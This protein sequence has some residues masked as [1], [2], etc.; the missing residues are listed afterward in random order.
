MNAACVGLCLVVL[1]AWTDG[2]RAT[3]SRQIELEPCQLESDAGVASVEAECGRLSVPEDRAD[4]SGRQIE[5]RVAVVRAGSRDPAQTPLFVLAGGPGQA[6][7][8]FYAAYAPAFRWVQR[9]RDIV[10]VDQ[11]GTGGSSA[12]RC[13]EDTDLSTPAVFDPTELRDRAASCLAELA[14]DPRHYT[15]SVAVRDLDTVREALGYG[16]IDLYGVSYGTRVAQH[17]LRRF[18]GQVRAMVLDGAVP[19]EVVLGPDTGPEA[20]RALDAILARCVA[21]PRCSAAFPNVHSDFVELV[22]RLRQAPLDLSVP[23]PTTAEPIALRFDAQQLGAALRI[24]S[25]SDETAALLPLLI[26]EAADRGYAEPLAAQYLMVARRL[27]GQLAEGMHNAVVCTED[28]PF[29][30]P[31]AA[32]RPA[33]TDAYLG[34]LQ[35]EGLAAICSVWPR[36]ELDDDLRSPLTIEV[37][38][39]LL[40]GEFD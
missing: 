8:E 12:L 38:L 4:P 27:G 9:A 32:T 39:L 11:R 40:S 1:A 34:T 26:N 17:Y 28:V 13:P 29:I 10:L 14:G 7:T 19:P 30:D 21:D 2:D 31:G 24:L 15:T 3:D 33:I 16:Q 22:D 37:P 6:A 23:D 36:G 35:L 25:Y 20:Q 18:P 5:L